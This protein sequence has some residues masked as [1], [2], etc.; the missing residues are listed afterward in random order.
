[1]DKQSV[2]DTL[3]GVLLRPSYLIRIGRHLRNRMGAGLVLLL[4][5]AACYLILRFIVGF[6][7]DLIR[8]GVEDIGRGNTWVDVVP[9][10]GS[11]IT[12][13]IFLYV[14]GLL[15]QNVVGRWVVRYTEQ[16]IGRIPFLRGVYNTARQATNLLSGLESAK[17]SRVVLVSFPH[18]KARS[19]GLVT[20][21]WSTPGGRD[22]LQVYVPTTP[23][24]MSGFLL[25]VDESEVEDAGMSTDTAL[26]MVVTA[27]ITE[28]QNGKLAGIA[29]P[30]SFPVEQSG[31]SPAPGGQT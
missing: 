26:R 28:R 17:F 31:T 1:M 4:P 3:P 10:V 25:F 21:R 14:V 8:P 9:P 12:L 22:Y 20:G 2:R 13:V 23:T 30:E 27:G 5:A 19:I 18:A 15:A 24:P 7:D 29:P 6:V 16:A 11:V